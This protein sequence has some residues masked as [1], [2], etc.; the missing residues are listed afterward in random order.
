[1]MFNVLLSKTFFDQ[2]KIRPKNE[3]FDQVG[4]RVGRQNSKKKSSFDKK[5]THLRKYVDLWSD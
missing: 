3:D 1:M 4:D 2:L 5:E